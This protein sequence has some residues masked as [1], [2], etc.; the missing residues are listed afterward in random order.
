MKI[1]HSILSHEVYGSERFCAELAAAQAVGGD[2]VR[3]LI[4]G[5]RGGEYVR[6]FEEVVGR[7]WLVV[8]PAWWPGVLDGWAARRVIRGFA[9]DVVHCHLGRAAKRVG[10]AA[11]REKVVAV[12]SLHLGYKA[13]LYG[14][15]DGIACV[16]AWQRETLKGFGGGVAVVRNWA[17]QG[18]GNGGT[19]EQRT[20]LRASLGVGEGDKMIGSVGRLEAQKGYDVLIPSFLEAYGAREDVHLVLVGEGSERPKLEAL[21]GGHPR[22]HLVGFQTPMGPW[23]AAMDAFVSSSRFE[24]LALV[25]LE[26]LAQGLPMLLTDVA[27]NRELV[28]L[29]NDGMIGLVPVEDVNALAAGLRKLDWAK[30]TYDLS[31]LDKGNAVRGMGDFYREVLVAKK[32][33]A[34]V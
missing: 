27:G 20:A 5:A 19:E 15:L 9:P 18:Q 3:V 29:Q 16:A 25:G 21:A 7:D 1:L 4:K 26:A 6:Y 8:L 13:K 33:A 34:P 2:E 30:K 23:W 32:A 14:H 31:A 24:G 17:R 28:E 10:M 22:V 12:A 11:R